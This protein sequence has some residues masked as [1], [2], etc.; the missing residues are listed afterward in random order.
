MVKFSGI[1][2]AVLKCKYAELRRLSYLLGSLS[3]HAN[4]CFDE[5]RL[6]AESLDL[7]AELRYQVIVAHA[8]LL[9]HVVG[10][11]VQRL[12]TI[13][14]LRLVASMAYHNQGFFRLL[15]HELIGVSSLLD[16]RTDH[17][18]DTWIQVTSWKLLKEHLE[19]HAGVLGYLRPEVV[20]L[21]ND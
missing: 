16:K 9:F 20:R 15:G 7:H 14:N 1:R 8:S 5:P 17:E 10:S 4:D 6:F 12:K 21:L 13:E 3:E 2:K 19:G 18:V 11:E